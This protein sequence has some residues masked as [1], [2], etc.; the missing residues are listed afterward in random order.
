MQSKE[1][2][3]QGLWKKGFWGAEIIAAQ[4][5]PHFKQEGEKGGSDYNSQGGPGLKQEGK[6]G[7]RSD[8]SLDLGEGENLLNETSAHLIT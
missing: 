1:S 3:D 8:N 6:T 5:G 7:I 2:N 4:G